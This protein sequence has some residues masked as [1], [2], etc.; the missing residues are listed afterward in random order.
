LQTKINTLVRLQLFVQWV[1]V[2]V[3]ALVVKCS[4]MTGHDWFV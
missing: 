2:N 4:Y 3:L 1:T